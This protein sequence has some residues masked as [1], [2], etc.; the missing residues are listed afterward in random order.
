MSSALNIGTLAL[1]ANLSALQV[2]GHNIANANTAGYSRQTVE[3]RSSGYQTLGGNFYG[4]G[5]ELG[6]VAREHDVYLTRE[7]QMASS[8]A[9]ADSERLARL[10]QLENLFPTGEAGLG[11]AMND[12]LNAWSD[13]S[14]SPTNLAARSVV[15]GRGEE[16]ASRMRDTAGQ[17]DV[18]A[19]SARQQVGDTVDNINRLAGEIGLIN[20]KIIETQGSAGE[21]ND[22]LDQRDSLIGEL[23]QLVQVSTVAADDGSLSVF[24]AGSQPLVLGRNAARLAVVPDSTDASMP[25]WAVSCSSSAKT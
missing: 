18:L 12:L 4:M 3:M 11:A 13:V 1:N 24:V 22:L 6:T 9:S 7:A 19:S 5:V 14:S 23:S 20:Q 10:Q 25:S 8:V 15:I 16:L 2:I 17:V 21:P